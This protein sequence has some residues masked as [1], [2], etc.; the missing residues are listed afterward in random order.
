M[1]VFIR[2][3][4]LCMYVYILTHTRFA[5]DTR[6]T[7]SISGMSFQIRIL[8]TV[9]TRSTPSFIPD[10][11]PPTMRSFSIDLTL[12]EMVFSFSKP[13]NSQRCNSSALVLGQ[14]I[15]VRNPQVWFSRGFW[16]VD[17]QS[18]LIPYTVYIYH[19]IQGVS[20]HSTQ[21]RLGQHS[22]SDNDGLSSSS[23]SFVMHLSY[24]DYIG[25]KVRTGHLCPVGSPIQSTFSSL[26]TL[27]VDEFFVTDTYGNPLDATYS[28]HQHTALYVLTVLPDT[29]PPSLLVVY[30][31]S[32]VRLA[33]YFDDAVNVSYCAL[34]SSLNK[35]FFLT[36]TGSTPLEVNI[37]MLVPKK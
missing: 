31:V 9:R 1:Y 30:L 13:V 19:Y 12:K 22:Y 15:H 33:L 16:V 26:C 37:Y 23:L 10:T 34:P 21:F 32:P 25:I 27:H 20:N 28:A 8:P 29:V 18:P 24:Y 2:H 5:N 4:M 11:L 17:V 7:N 14:G 6:T 35:F 3:I 36:S